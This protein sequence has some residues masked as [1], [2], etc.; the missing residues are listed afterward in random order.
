MVSLRCTVP[1]APLEMSSRLAAGKRKFVEY[2]GKKLSYLDVGETG[3][4]ALLLCHGLAANGAQFA[5]DAIYFSENGYRVVVPDLFGHGYSHPT[6]MVDLKD[7]SISALGKDIIAII[8]HAEIDEVAF[9]GNSLGGLVGLGLMKSYKHRLSCFASFGTTYSLQTPKLAIWMLPKIY[10]LLGKRLVAA[11]GALGVSKKSETRDKVRQMFGEC[12]LSTVI[13]IAVQIGNYD[14]IKHAVDFDKPIL[15]LR[16]LADNSI[17]PTLG[18]TLTAM[19][20]TSHFKLVDLPDAGHCAN[21]DSPEM[22]R[23][24]LLRF[25]QAI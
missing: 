25:L 1:N 15:F 19:Q 18:P 12:D 2:N 23:S 9:V 11:L 4:P 14:L 5:A 22:F 7:C 3:A 8:D 13:K 16:G 20:A 17:K 10:Q 21:L 6:Q 24:E